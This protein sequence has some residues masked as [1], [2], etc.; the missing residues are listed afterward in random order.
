MRFREKRLWQ[1]VSLDIGPLLEL[2]IA[3]L[4]SDESRILGGSLVEP[5]ECLLGVGRILCGLVLRFGSLRESFQ[6]SVL[7]AIVTNIRRS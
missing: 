3:A 1:N 7:L 2:V 4:Q 6:G 5:Q